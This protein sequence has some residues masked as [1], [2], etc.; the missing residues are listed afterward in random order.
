MANS[1]NWMNPDTGRNV[2]TGTNFMERLL[3]GLQ[4][5]GMGNAMGNLGMMLMSAGQGGG[6]TRPRF[7]PA[8]MQMYN[9]KS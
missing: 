2:N 1:Y 4:R 5:P 8:Q 9:H 7:G 6:P 3:G